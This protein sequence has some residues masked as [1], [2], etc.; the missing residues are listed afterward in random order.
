MKEGTISVKEYQFPQYVVLLIASVIIA[1]MFE[2]FIF[3]R[4]H[5]RILGNNIND[6]VV[7]FDDGTEL[8][9]GETYSFDNGFSII[10][11]DINQDVNNYYLDIG[12]YYNEKWNEER[13]AALH[14]TTALKDEGHY[15]F[16][17]LKELLISP[18]VESSLF[19]PIEAYGKVNSIR[20]SFKEGVD[21]FSLYGIEL[22]SIKPLSLSCFRLLLT[23]AIIYFFALLFCFEYTS[24]ENINIKKRIG[25]M[26]AFGLILCLFAF[27]IQSQTIERGAHK[28]YPELARS[29]IDGKLYVEKNTDEVL[30]NMDN[31]YDLSLRQKLGAKY[32][33]DTAYYND[34]YYIYFG[35]VPALIFQLP[36]YLITG[37]DMLYAQAQ[38]IMSILIIVGS[39]CLIEELRKKYFPSIPIR[40]EV[41][42]YITFIFSLGFSILLKR[43]AIYYEAIGTAIMLVIWGVFFWIHSIRDN[44]ICIWQGMVGSFL[45]AASVGARPQFAIA[46][47]LAFYVYRKFLDIKHIKCMLLLQLPYIPVAISLM[48]YNYFRFGSAFDFGANY[49]LTHHDMTHM[50]IHIS[51]IAMGVWYYIFKLPILDYCFPFMYADGNRNLYQGYIAYEPQIGGVLFL[52]PYILILVINKFNNRA[53][54]TLARCSFIATTIVIIA[55]SVLCGILVRYQL[56]YRLILAFSAMIVNIV[57]MNNLSDQGNKKVFN[58][59]CTTTVILCVMTIILN[60]CLIVC[61]YESGDYADMRINPVFFCK[62]RAFFGG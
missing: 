31:P 7:Y 43:S 5:F 51:R 21:E 56:D 44:R 45:M 46:S 16:Y 36:Y 62:A 38:D 25:I 35:V 18:V 24:E 53:E 39:L 48:L 19:V 6:P 61:Q 58:W 32:Y 26:M 47:F 8:K 30:R 40:L 27:D 34:N 60:L 49:N 22:N 42:L 4:E 10:I 2:I 59:Y 11:K 55:D 41:L 37:Q 33:W 29:I 1:M 9:Y 50:G 23:I 13:L 17:S 28:G 14:I 54:R 3:N 15:E 52:V 20:I 57:C 12:E